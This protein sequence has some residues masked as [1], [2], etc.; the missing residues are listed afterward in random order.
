ML[1]ALL[2]ADVLWEHRNHP[3]LSLVCTLPCPSEKA[4]PCLLWH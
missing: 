1:S 3:S 2:H 4:L